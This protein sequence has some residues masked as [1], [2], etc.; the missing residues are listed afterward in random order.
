MGVGNA[1]KFPTILVGYGCTWGYP[2]VAC[3]FLDGSNLFCV[4]LAGIETF[5]KG[6]P[7]EDVI[8]TFDEF[9]F[10]FIFDMPASSFVL[11]WLLL[12]GLNVYEHV[13][14]LQNFSHI[15]VLKICGG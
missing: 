2:L 5:R 1:A 4:S 8:D 3:Y 6:L 15:S 7:A 13:F 10:S 14:F 12:S 9:L 11:Q